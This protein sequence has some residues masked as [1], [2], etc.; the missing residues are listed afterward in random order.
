VK[1]T[2]T[3]ENGEEREYSILVERDENEENYITS[4][5]LSFQHLRALILQ[6]SILM[7]KTI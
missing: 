6:Q 4:H 5:H 7:M 3:A 2:V 1:F